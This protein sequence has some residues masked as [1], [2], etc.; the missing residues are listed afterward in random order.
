MKFPET[1]FIDIKLVKPVA[2]RKNV[3]RQLIVAL[4]NSDGDFEML[5]YTTEGA[6]SPRLGLLVHHTDGVREYAYDHPSKVGQLEQGLDQAK[7][8]GWVLIDMKND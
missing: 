4:D 8:R 3:G 2:S 7:D 5:E 6:K 1:D